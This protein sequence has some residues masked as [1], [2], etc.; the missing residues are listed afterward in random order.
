MATRLRRLTK[1]GRRQLVEDMACVLVGELEIGNDQGCI[2]A[3]LARG[4]HPRDISDCLDTAR[5]MAR[6]ALVDEAGLWERLMR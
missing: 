4:F 2:M 6:A 1:E 3:L 5:S